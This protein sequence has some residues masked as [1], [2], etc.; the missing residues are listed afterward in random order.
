MTIV[1]TATL[2]VLNRMAKLGEV[3][4]LM[5]V[6]ISNRAALTPETKLEE[7]R[8][9]ASLIMGALCDIAAIMADGNPSAIEGI[10]NFRKHMTDS[11]EGLTEEN[12]PSYGDLVEQVTSLL[13]ASSERMQALRSEP[14]VEVKRP[15][16]RGSMMWRACKKQA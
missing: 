16:M 9:R 3:A 7:G 10:N 11:L 8:I 15:P 4:R 1:T 12:A 13:H 14:A 6:V 5:A 2:F